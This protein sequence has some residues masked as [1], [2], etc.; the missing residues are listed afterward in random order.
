MPVIDAHQHFWKY[1]AEEFGWINDDMKVI[2]KDFL[3]ADL[4][5][6][7]AE[8]NIDG[9]IAVQTKQTEEENN[10]LLQLAE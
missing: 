8:N 1:N 7:L 9:C 3:P 4:K 2:R 10:F 6:L 5:P